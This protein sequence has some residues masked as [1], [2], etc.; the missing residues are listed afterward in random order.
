MHHKSLDTEI[1]S[2]DQSETFSYTIRRCY[3]LTMAYSVCTVCLT[4]GVKFQGVINEPFIDFSLVWFQKYIFLHI[5]FRFLT[6]ILIL[7]SVC[8]KYF[9]LFSNFPNHIS[10]RACIG[11]ENQYWLYAYG[12]LKPLSNHW[13]KLIH[14]NTCLTAADKQAHRQ[15]GRQTDGQ[16]DQIDEHELMRKTCHACGEW[17][18][19]FVDLTCACCPRATG[20]CWRAVLTVTHIYPLSMKTIDWRIRPDTVSD[21]VWGIAKFRCK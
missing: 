3:L 21:A 5:I 12:R 13:S 11:T 10:H 20:P 8:K 6:C 15:A 1:K 14:H 9:N 19:L 7:Y 18:C 4:P 16:T 17:I 2:T